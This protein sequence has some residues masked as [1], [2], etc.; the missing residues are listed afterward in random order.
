MLVVIM[1]RSKMFWLPT[2]IEALSKPDS[3]MRIYCNCDIEKIIYQDGL[4]EGVEGKFYQ[5]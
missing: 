4:V 5:Y 2:S 3:T 1:K